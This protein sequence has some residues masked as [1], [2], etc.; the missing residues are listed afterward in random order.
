MRKVTNSSEIIDSGLARDQEQGAALITTLLLLTLLMAMTLSMTISVTSDTLIS[1]YYRNAQSS[2]YAADSGLNIARQ[3]MMN[4]LSA[5]ALSV[6]STFTT[7][8]APPLSATDA[9]TTLTNVLSQYSS[10]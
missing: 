7:T 6:G 2:F 4:Q 9:S 3:Y 5:N 10:S 1:R 8:S